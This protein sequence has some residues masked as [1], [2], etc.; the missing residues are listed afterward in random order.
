[1][2]SSC[3]NEHEK[4]VFNNKEKK[5]FSSILN[6]ENRERRG[7]RRGEC[8]GILLFSGIKTHPDPFYV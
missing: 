4:G 8:P 2:H 7:R 3:D 6:E 1:V 5:R